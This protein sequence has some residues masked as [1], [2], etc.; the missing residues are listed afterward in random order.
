VLKAH[1]KLLEH[2][3]LAGDLVVV[4]AFTGDA[5]KTKL[6][7]KALETIKTVVLRRGAK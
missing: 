5:P 3:M 2:I 4:K 7:A 6:L 1:S